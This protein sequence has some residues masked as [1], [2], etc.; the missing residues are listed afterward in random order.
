MASGSG[1]AASHPRPPGPQ[2]RW[3][4]VD[5][6]ACGALCEVAHLQAFG[7]RTATARQHLRSRTG[8][9]CP[10]APEV[11]PLAR[12]DPTICARPV[13]IGRRRP[14]LCV[15][16]LVLSRVAMHRGVRHEAARAPTSQPERLPTRPALPCSDHEQPPY[17]VA[18]PRTVGVVVAWTRW[19]WLESIANHSSAM[20]RA[21][22]RNRASVV[23]MVWGSWVSI[24]HAP[25]LGGERMAGW[26]E[27]RP[28]ADVP[29][30]TE[31]A[32][33]PTSD[34]R[35]ADTGTLP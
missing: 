24:E 9:R 4:P 29:G 33:I 11:M 25:R 17:F 28:G 2:G 3:F 35:R 32:V 22:A 19:K 18:E 30:S 6:V 14:A 21:A 26:D 12:T 10:V 5:L 27:G 20:S 13:Q 34:A 15:E 16:H 7:T 8:T 1:A 23:L 31:R